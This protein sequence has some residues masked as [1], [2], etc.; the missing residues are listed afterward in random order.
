MTDID[1]L[2][3]KLFAFLKGHGLKIKIFDETGFETVNPS[4]GRR[5][6]IIHPNIMITINTD[7]NSVEFNKG[8]KVGADSA[9]LQKGIKKL[10]DE[11]LMN[12]TIRVF[13]RTIQPR[14]YS[15]QAKIKKDEGIMEGSNI[16][17]INHHLLGQ[18]YRKIKYFKHAYDYTIADDLG[19]GLEDVRP[20][21]NVLVKD[22]KIKA[23]R[24]P[25]GTISYSLAIDEAITEGFSKLRGS[26][27]TSRQHLDNVQIIVNHKLPVDESIQGSRS[28]NIASIFLE[29]DGVKYRFPYKYLPGARAMARHLSNGGSANDALGVYITESTGRLLKLQSFNKYVT[30]NNLITE[31][32]VKAVTV[33][34]E[35]LNLLKVELKKISS[36]RQYDTT[37]ARVEC[38][39]HETLQESDTSDLRDMFSL[40]HFDKKFEEIL[41][42]VKSL[43]KEK[44]Q[45]YRRIEEAANTAVY[46]RAILDESV[47]S[48]E[49]ANENARLGFKISQ[50]SAQILENSELA[51]FVGDVGTK[52]SSNTELNSFEKV[53][54]SKVLENLVTGTDQKSPSALDLTECI[55]YED[56]FSKYEYLDFR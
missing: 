20:V 38:L 25:R 2:A 42:V 11:F 19:M 43:L 8:N 3:E 32:S 47:P 16:H 56:F 7:N 13:G 23:E 28:R 33:I 53:I 29:C 54:V 17:P 31:A 18:V 48:L 46:V 36:S 55:N 12:F 26:A 14:D 6:F 9:N 21:L 22:G 34:K 41:P 27:K 44:D 4:S 37:K 50:L 15:Y 49:F 51:A 30:N 5:F 35:N 1:T 10:C 24:E 40:R 45:Y 52:L 39:L